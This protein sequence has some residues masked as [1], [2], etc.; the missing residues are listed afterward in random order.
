MI[1]VQVV[2]STVGRDESWIKVETDSSSIHWS[3][4]EDVKAI[5]EDAS[6]LTDKTTPEQLAPYIALDDW[7]R[8]LSGDKVC[9]TCALTSKFSRSFC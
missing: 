6:T 9:Y 5:F 2:V 4:Q 3:N 1:K 8:S 7:V